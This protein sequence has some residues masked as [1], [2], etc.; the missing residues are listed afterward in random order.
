MRR[1]AVA[2][3]G[4]RVREPGAGEH[5]RR[6]PRDRVLVDVAADDV[7]RP[8]RRA[9]SSATAARASRPRLACES[10]SRC[11]ETARTS[12][13]VARCTPE[14]AAAWLPSSV[15]ATSRNAI[16]RKAAR[17]TI[18]A[19]PLGAHGISGTTQSDHQSRAL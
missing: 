8:R 9:G 10:L 1:L 14:K 13:P 6:R 11:T 19:V 5:A 18:T 15:S 4:E 2:H 7:R 3:R 16:E 12:R 17:R